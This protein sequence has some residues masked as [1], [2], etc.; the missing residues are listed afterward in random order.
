M[1]SLVDARTYKKLKAE[2]SFPPHYKTKVLMHKVAKEPVQ[3]WM[4]KKLKSALGEDDYEIPCMTLWGYLDMSEQ[5]DPYQVHITAIPFLGK[6]RTTRFC[7]GLWALLLDAQENG[8][9]PQSFA[10]KQAKAQKKL[11]QSV[12][13]EADKRDERHERRNRRR[14]RSRSDSR[15][16]RRRRSRERS[17]ERDYDRRDEREGRRRSRRDS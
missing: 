8:G 12:Q 16:R 6:E 17:R 1:V 14:D 13:A 9:V 11:A 3:A 7:G 10:A 15:D 5:P 4:E 2:L